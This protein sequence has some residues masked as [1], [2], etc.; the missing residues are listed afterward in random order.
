MALA[1]KQTRTLPCG[2]MRVTLHLEE[3]N[4]RGPQSKAL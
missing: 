2:L 3:E 4:T 1:P